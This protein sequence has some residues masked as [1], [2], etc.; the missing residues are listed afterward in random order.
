MAFSMF[1]SFL[2]IKYEF[3]KNT[4]KYIRIEMK[5]TKLSVIIYR[6]VKIKPN[7]GFYIFIISLII[8]FIERGAIDEK[9]K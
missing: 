6:V 9:Q 3:S 5:I 2:T 4:M 7:L 1:Y 8:F